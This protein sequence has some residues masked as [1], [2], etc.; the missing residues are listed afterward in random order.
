[1]L[2]TKDRS[3]AEPANET[4]L[5]R[6]EIRQTFRYCRKKKRKRG[7]INQQI[8]Q[9][10]SPKAGFSKVKQRKKKCYIRIQNEINTIRKD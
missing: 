7:F 2:P 6:K 3:S 5:N 1:L 4:D 10:Y 8:S 9:I